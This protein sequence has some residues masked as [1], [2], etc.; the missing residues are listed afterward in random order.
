MQQ[1]RI[2]G[3]RKLRLERVI[4]AASAPVVSRKYVVSK[5]DLEKHT[6]MTPRKLLSAL[7]EFVVTTSTSIFFTTIGLGALL[8]FGLVLA[9]PIA[10]I[11]LIYQYLF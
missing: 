2:T 6:G 10:A 7:W 3:F 9:L 11:L 1:N 4:K 8:V 5:G